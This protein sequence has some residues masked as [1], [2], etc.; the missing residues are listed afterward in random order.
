MGNEELCGASR[1]HVME[2]KEG[3][4][5][6][7]NIAIFL[8]YVLPSLVS[9]VFVAILLVWLLTFWKRNKQR[10]PRAEDTLDVELKRISYYEIL[11]ATEDFDE[12][13]LIGRGSFSSVF[14]GTF[15][16]G[17]V[18]AIKVFNLDVQDSIRSFEVECQV[19]RNVRHRNL[20]KVITSCSNLDFKALILEYMPNGSLHKWLYSHN[21][22]LDIYQRLGIMMD[23]A[24]A[25]EYMHHGHSFPVVHCDLKPGNILLDE[26]MVAHVGD[27]G[28]A[29]LLDK[30]KTTKQ[31][32]IMGTVG[33]MAPEYGSA[34]IISSMG[35]VYS[36]GILLM[37]VF[38]RKKPTDE[39]FQGDF[40]M[41]RWVS[42]S[43]PDAIMQIVDSNL[44]TGEE[45]GGQEIEECFLM[46]MGLAVECTADF[47]EERMSIEDVAVRLKHTL[48]KFTQNTS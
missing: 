44:L 19:L 20:V 9:V 33:Y 16:A 47:P 41:R 30:D 3:K 32:K 26:N 22:F 12:S 46:V 35:D 42:E 8:K 31:T 29:K 39:M 15:A 10:K 43:L 34:G 27:V 13:N 2:C 28:I 7:R 36:F 17:L 24:N 25:L 14:K 21:Y 23:I 40:T 5:K 1:F 4:G 18:A 6:P 45:G 11:G 48:H 38:T 37:E